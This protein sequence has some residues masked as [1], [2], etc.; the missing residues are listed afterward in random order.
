MKPKGRAE[1]K[2]VIAYG[3][4]CWIRDLRRRFS[5]RTRDLV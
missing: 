3:E 4:W 5:F 2:K 1:K